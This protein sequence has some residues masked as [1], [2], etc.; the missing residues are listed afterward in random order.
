MM[1]SIYWAKLKRVLRL[2]L[3]L[4][5]DY[6]YWPLCQLG[7]NLSRSK[8]GTSLGKM[9]PYD[10]PGRKSVVRFLVW[11]LKWE[12][13]D[14][15]G[16]CHFWAVSSGGSKKAGWSNHEVS[17]LPE[18]LTQLLWTVNSKSFLPQVALAMVNHS[19]RN[20]KAR[21]ET[22]KDADNDDQADEVCPRFL[23]ERALLK[24]AGCGEPSR[25]GGQNEQNWAAIYLF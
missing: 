4:F 15:H 3:L 8:K 24:T 20:P 14:H 12:G 11:W 18:L 13:R 21:L 7:T 16:W 19:S 10:L 17:A 22:W 25:A 5:G 23:L 2:V 6:L 9:P 1:F